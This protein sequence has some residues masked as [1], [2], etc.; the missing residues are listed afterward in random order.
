M[1]TIAR[2]INDDACQGVTREE[3][4][5]FRRAIARMTANLDRVMR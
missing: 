1:L 3:L 4:D 2:G 5:A